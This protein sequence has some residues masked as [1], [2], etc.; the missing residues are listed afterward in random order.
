MNTTVVIMA[1]GGGTRLWPLS[2][3]KNPKQFLAFGEE[4][5]LLQKTFERAKLLTPISNIFVATMSEYGE[6]I[7]ETL[8][9]VS[10]DN[11]FYEPQRRDNA[12][13]MAS[14]AVRLMLKGKE[15]E[16]VIFMWADHVFTDEEEFVGDLKRM[17]AILDQNPNSIVIMGHVPTTPETG[18]GYIETDGASVPGFKDVYRVKSFKEKPDRATAETYIMAGTYYWNLGYVLSYPQYLLDE[19]QKYEPELMK[20]IASFKAALEKGDEEEANRIYGT[21]PKTSIDYAV[22]ERTPTLFAITGDYGWSDVGNWSTVHDV[23]GITGDHVPRGHNI[24]VDSEN[25]YIYNAT[26]RAISMVGM[27][28]TIVV[29]TEDAIL[30]TAK[31]DA[32][33]VKDVVARLEKEGKTE[34]L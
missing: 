31:S 9:E 20:G 3:H 12:A 5:N 22:L 11:I 30:V 23:F 4:K 13:A 8:S 17:P 34:L 19:L 26:D 29:V 28:N 25:N 18:L 2:R 27:K 21:L 7:K 6:R 33:K 32:Y 16:P 14:A 24:H 10:E 1:G 15:K